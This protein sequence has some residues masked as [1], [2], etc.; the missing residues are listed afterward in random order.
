VLDQSFQVLPRGD[1]H[2]FDIDFQQASLT[3]TPLPMKVFGFTK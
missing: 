3:E 1:H 2:S